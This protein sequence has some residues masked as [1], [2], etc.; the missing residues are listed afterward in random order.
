MVSDD[1]VTQVLLLFH[2]SCCLLPVEVDALMAYSKPDGVSLARISCHDLSRQ[3]LNVSITDS[4]VNIDVEVLAN[5]TYW[6]DKKEK[7][8]TFSC[9]TVIHYVVLN[10]Y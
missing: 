9:I 6:I 4:M 8:F 10:K 7:V 2:Q 3:Q 5:R 1:F